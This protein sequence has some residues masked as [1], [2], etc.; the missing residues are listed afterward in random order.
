ML[1]L[2]RGWVGGDDEKAD[3]RELTRSVKGSRERWMTEWD[4]EGTI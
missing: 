4:D 2:M 1:M 3:H